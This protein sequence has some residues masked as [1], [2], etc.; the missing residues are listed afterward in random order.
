MGPYRSW[1]VS[2]SRIGDVIHV[3]FPEISNKTSLNRIA[4][5]IGMSIAFYIHSVRSAFASAL[6]GGLM[7]A[8]AAYQA[9]LD[10]DIKLENETHPCEKVRK[11]LVHHGIFMTI[12]DET[13]QLD[14][15][16]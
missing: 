12:L 5:S 3:Y 4:K 16:I 13:S 8:R 1:L 2:P 14:V 9:C 15:A 7:I 11:D 10:R 6:T